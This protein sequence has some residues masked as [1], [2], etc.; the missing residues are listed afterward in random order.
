MA[1]LGDLVVRLKAETADFQQDMGKSALM[2][3]R[4]MRQINSAL[5]LIGTGLA[6]A[7]FVA[8]IKNT[9]DAADHLNDLSKT[10]RISVES[11]SG[12]SLLARQSG[13]DLDSMAQA[14]N[15]LS[16]NIGKDPEKFKALGISAKEPL[17][18]FKQLSDLFITLPDQEQRAAVM[19][20]ALGKS[21]AGAAP[22]LAEGSRRIGEIVERGA[23][24]SGMT[25]EMAEKSDELN[26]KWAELVGTGGLVNSIVGKMLDPLLRLTNQ[27]ILARDGAN[28]FVSAIGRFFSL[29]GD[30][31]KNPQA[32]L[33]A[34]EQKLSTLRKTADDFAGMNLFKRIFSADD[35]AIVNAQIATLEAKKSMLEGL[36]GASFPGGGTPSTGDAAAAAARAAAF[37]REDKTIKAAEQEM[38][39]YTSALQRLEEQLGKL[40]NMTAYEKTLYELVHGSLERITLDHGAELLA[41]ARSV[42]ARNQHVAVVES[43]YKWLGELAEQQERMN[44][45]TAESVRQD[46]LQNDQ[47]AFQLTLIGKTAA[48]QERMNALRAVDLQ[49]RERLR[50]AEALLPEDAT[51][52]ARERS[53]AAIMR[54]VEAQ[55]KFITENLAARTKAERDW[56]TGVK[57]AFN[58]YLESA[59]NAAEQSRKFFGDAFRGIEDF[60]VDS[61]MTAKIEMD[62]VR[63]L[64]KLLISDLIRIQVQRNIMLPLIGTAKEPGILTRGLESIAGSILGSIGS[65]I[66]GLPGRATGGPVIAGNSYMINEGKPEVFT[67]GVSGQMT[68]IGGISR[69]GNTFI[70]NISA[71]KQFGPNVMNGGPVFNINMPGATLEAVM[72]VERF[73]MAVNGS[74]ERRALNAV[75]DSSRRGGRR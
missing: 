27:M 23:K 50:A 39:L 68:P 5:R 40:N 41:V 46:N 42:D 73:V 34:V 18:A 48:E 9:I 66:F 31:A 12:L 16:V 52:E 15:K 38:K 55:K 8:M 7:G 70:P 69:G 54:T 75:A 43:E 2:A 47:M 60:I 20:A 29:G 17:E 58:E 26:D 61:M 64:A 14:I 24:L 44:G 51:A 45:L 36:L 11:L 30:E 22:A 49:T 3:E 57:G 37:L 21:W 1:W 65:S 56:S 33:D 67:P 6:G 74:I 19:A 63:N 28:G 71:D 59:S 25:K 4:S 72:R 35:I 62:S 32:A 10:T 13:S 53:A